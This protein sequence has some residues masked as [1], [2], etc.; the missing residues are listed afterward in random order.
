MTHT[1]QRTRVG[2]NPEALA[3]KAIVALERA[4]REEF[5]V[6]MQVGAEL[7]Y[8]VRVPPDLLVTKKIKE[9]NNPLQVHPHAPDAQERAAGTPALTVP[10]VASAPDST[11]TIQVRDPLFPES[12][13]VSYSYHEADRPG[14]GWH[15]YETIVPH[16]G[17][18]NAVAFGDGR[19][20][21][22]ARI[23]EALRKTVAHTPPSRTRFAEDP[24]HNAWLGR[25]AHGITERSTTALG[26]HPDDPSIV[27][28]MHINLSFSCDGTPF[29][30]G[31]PD[32]EAGMG[33]A[34]ALQRGMAE[35]FNENAYLLHGTPESLQRACYGM[36][37]F[38]H[39]GVRG[40]SIHKDE[41]R[42]PVYLEVRRPPSDANPYYAA[43]VT[44]LGV[45]H[46]LKDYG[47]D[48]ATQAFAQT[49]KTRPFT[50]N[51]IP[52][53]PHPDTPLYPESFR[54][55]LDLAGKMKAQFTDK[56]RLLERTLNTLEPDLG[57]RF[58]AA[59]E[60]TPPGAE[61]TREQAGIRSR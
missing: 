27:H 1:E 60:R 52:G 47:F 38:E 26:P 34:R 24:D 57:S 9:M 42:A 54:R 13:L 37:D 36:H 32:A 15:V 61:K 16:D 40:M 43:M 31:H 10:D 14:G 8:E 41:H 18:Q 6:D 28:G 59:V 55:H 12:G 20:N 11:K 22:L 46:T 7:E 19:M 23:I 2:E 4:L 21:G 35:A 30:T 56:H 5:G 45:Y 49:E 51:P 50:S 3:K 25:M 53:A 58:M 48:R 29:F 39:Q 17:K 44:L 33:K